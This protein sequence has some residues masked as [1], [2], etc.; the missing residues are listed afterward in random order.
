MAAPGGPSLH[1]IAKT[2][3]YAIQ[4]FVRMM[5]GKLTVVTVQPTDTVEQLKQRIY[6]REG[7][8]PDHMHL[9]LDNVHKILGDGMRLVDYG[10][11]PNQTVL[12]K[13]RLCAFDPSPEAEPAAAAA[14]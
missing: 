8:P 6:E 11:G 9:I 14:K 12:V 10:V 13:L 2:S 3:Q 7:I 1:E 5:T 4:I